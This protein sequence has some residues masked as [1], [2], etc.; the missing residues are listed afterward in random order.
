MCSGR[1]VL[2]I[3]YLAREKRLTNFTGEF[4]QT[5]K[6]VRLPKRSHKSYGAFF[7]KTNNKKQ[8][9]QQLRLEV[10]TKHSRTKLNPD[11]SRVVYNKLSGR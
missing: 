1:E 3:V 5:F 9:Q 7:T 2:A 8:Q 10:N 11:Q 6:L 4:K